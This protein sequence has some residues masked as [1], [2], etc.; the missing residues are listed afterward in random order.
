MQECVSGH[1]DLLL[2]SH[3]NLRAMMCRT[4][5]HAH[6]RVSTVGKLYIIKELHACGDYYVSF[7]PEGRGEQAWRTP[8]SLGLVESRTMNVLPGPAG[9]GRT[10][11]WR[12][13]HGDPS[14]GPVKLPCHALRVLYFV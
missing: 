12:P 8:P 11:R 2:L 3:H 9:R 4:V 5:F 13:V 7:R 10:L 6:L 1:T 14:Q